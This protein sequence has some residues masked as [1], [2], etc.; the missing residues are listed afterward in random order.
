MLH[1]MPARVHGAHGAGTALVT[2]HHSS[3]S[4]LS[5]VCSI[6]VMFYMF[7]NGHVLALVASNSCARAVLTSPHDHV[8]P[9]DPA[10]STGS[11]RR[12]GS[13]HSTHST[14]LART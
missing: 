1:T 6:P 2:P 8:T 3:L 9:R 5:T 11:T 14:H 12:T 10:S 7:D 4:T 13:T